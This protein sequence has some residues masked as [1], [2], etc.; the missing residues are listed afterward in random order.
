MKIN[1]IKPGQI[2]KPKTYPY[3]A[4]NSSNDLFFITAHDF[5]ICPMYWKDIRSLSED[6][7]TPLPE[8]TKIEITV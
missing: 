4:V 6:I 2:Q 3:W 8:G 7:L 1:I 5:G